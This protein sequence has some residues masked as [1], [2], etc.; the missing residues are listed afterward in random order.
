MQKLTIQRLVISFFSGVLL[1]SCGSNP[2]KDF[3]KTHV[4]QTMY[5]SPYFLDENLDYV[6]K[7]NISVYGNEFSGICIIKKIDKNMHRVVFTTEFGNKLLDF[8]VSEND[9]KVNAI[10][11]E[12]DR[13]I[14]TNTLKEDFRLLLREHFNVNARF[15]NHTDHI[16]ESA[17]GKM[18]NYLY[19][20]KKDNKLYKVGHTSKR[21]EKFSI[22]FTSENNIFANKT[23]IDHQ[24]IKLKI[25][26]NH[27]RN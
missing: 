11:E 18:F 17:D 9:F 1:V 4:D 25:E 3:N 21:K 15:E 22:T 14:L 26:L 24:N 6:Y 23:V 13:K 8:E 20:S 7:A 27:F 19:V 16:Y 12:L 2:M 5:T 10:V